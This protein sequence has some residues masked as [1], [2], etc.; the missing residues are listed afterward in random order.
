MNDTNTDT[1]MAGDYDLEELP[2]DSDGNR[3]EEDGDSSSGGAGG[4]H[5]HRY[6][7]IV[8]PFLD[9]ADDPALSDEENAE[10]KLRLL[11]ISPISVLVP[12][13]SSFASENDL[14]R[15]I[16]MA[17]VGR[18]NGEMSARDIADPD[19]VSHLDEKMRK[20]RT[21]FGL[22]HPSLILSGGVA[23]ATAAWAAFTGFSGGENPKPSAEKAQKKDQGKNAKLLDFSAGKESAF[24]S[25]SDDSYKGGIFP[26]SHVMQDPILEHATIETFKQQVEITRTAL[27]FDSLSSFF[28]FLSER[29]KAPVFKVKLQDGGKA[30]AD[31]GGPYVP[32][33]DDKAPR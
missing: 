23:L 14:S 26:D 9:F 16:F 29:A 30:G 32:W 31:V 12:G 13:A 20:R 15:K 3:E 25:K 4:K 7:V 27:D 5:P 10:R 11:A 22:P 33:G 8:E 17:D 19:L 28:N 18:S 1:D 2:F 6:R 21:L 24:S